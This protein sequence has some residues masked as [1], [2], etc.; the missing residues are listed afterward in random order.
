VQRL[1]VSLGVAR[2]PYIVLCVILLPGSAFNPRARIM[3]FL[4]QAKIYIRSGNGGPGAVTP[5]TSRPSAVAAARART[6]P[7]RVATTS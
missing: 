7:A 1:I 2:K 4:D 5:S 6:V 3:H